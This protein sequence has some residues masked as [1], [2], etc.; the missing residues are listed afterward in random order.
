MAQK[1]WGAFLDLPLL[2]IRG[3]DCSALLI[4]DVP[5]DA[6]DGLLGVWSEKASVRADM[7]R[8]MR[9]FMAIQSVLEMPTSSSYLPGLYIF[10]SSS[11]SPSL[12]SFILLSRVPR[13]VL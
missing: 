3:S 13:H 1:I 12:Q 6:S 9:Q 4:V 10:L 8:W 5:F 7:Q 11:S 2:A